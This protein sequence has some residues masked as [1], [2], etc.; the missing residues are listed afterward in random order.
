MAKRLLLIGGGG[1]AASVVEVV[2]G[3]PE[4]EIVGIVERP[5]APCRHRKPAKIIGFDA[6][7]PQLL[8]TVDAALITLGQVK[9]PTPRIRLY[10]TLKQLN[11]PL[12]TLVAANASVASSAQLCAGTVVMQQ[13][14]VNAYVC[15]GENCIINSQALVEHD[16]QIGSHCH[17]ATG[18]CINGGVEI[19]VR[20]FIGSGAVIAQGVRLCEDVVIGAGS[21][22]IQDIMQP[23]IYGGNP[24]RRLK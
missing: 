4:W 12:A 22:V 18:A 14:L 23:G 7:L 16:V 1:H 15:I 10:Q 17:I 19:G 21:V 5:G 11:A 8:R 3:L 2:R 24:A 6:N 13:A 9:D 20:C